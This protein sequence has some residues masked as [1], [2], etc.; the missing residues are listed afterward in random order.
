MS[1][2]RRGLN[3]WLGASKV[4]S[5]RGFYYLLSQLVELNSITGHTTSN[6][7]FRLSC[8]LKLGS[9]VPFIMLDLN[10]FRQGMFYRSS[11]AL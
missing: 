9:G 1:R 2:V 10:L 7:Q 5:V 11:V 6:E 8:A 3:V 4:E